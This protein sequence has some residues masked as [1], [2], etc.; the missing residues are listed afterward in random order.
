M[1][2]ECLDFTRFALDYAKEKVFIPGW[3]QVKGETPLLTGFLAMVDRDGGLNFYDGRLRLKTLGDNGQYKE[4]EPGDYRDFIDEQTMD[5]SY[6]KFPFA[7][8]AGGLSLDPDNPTGVYRTN[9]LARLNVCSHIPT[10]FA[11][12]ELLEFR[13]TVGSTPQHT[14]LYHWARLIEAVFCAERALELL[15]DESITD[16]RVREKA[17][18]PAG[19]GV[20]VVEAPRGTLIHDY[21]ADEKGFITKLNLIVATTHNSAAMNLDVLRTARAVLDGGRSDEEALNKIE[22]V[23]R[24]Y[25]PCF[26]CATHHLN[27]SLPVRVDICDSSG[28]TIRTLIN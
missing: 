28:Y 8:S 6:V 18:P 27:G 26:S 15:Q 20:G 12:Q 21:E 1:A 22:T 13:Q 3:E 23:I 25:D 16:T 11:Q 2:R 14:F 17:S 9:S 4:F 19:R 5:W 24:A 10:P 7:K